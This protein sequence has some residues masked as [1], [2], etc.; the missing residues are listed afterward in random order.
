MQ[1]WLGA[2]ALAAVMLPYGS[3]TAADPLA[4]SQWRSRVL[5]I[6]AAHADN[7]KIAEQRAI[8]G[9]MAEGAR[10]RDLILVE[11]I[12]STPQSKAMRTRFDVGDG[13]FQAILVGKDGGEKLASD[14]PLGA[15]RLF[16]LID[17]MPMR[18]DE[19]RGRS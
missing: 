17:A 5:L 7:P 4:A 19:M 9:A 13:E 16:P 12:G 1:Q 14:E 2:A 18:R 10:E 15:E 8:F 11:A 6:I 3:A